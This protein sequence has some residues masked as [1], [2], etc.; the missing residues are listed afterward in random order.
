MARTL[1]LGTIGRQILLSIQCNEEIW[2]REFF[3]WKIEDCANSDLNIREKYWIKY[4]DSFGNNGYNLTIG[5]DGAYT[6]KH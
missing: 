4:Y 2:N 6:E 5:G 1:L 3:Y